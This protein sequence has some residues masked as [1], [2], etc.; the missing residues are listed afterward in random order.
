MLIRSIYVKH[1]LFL[2][3]PRFLEL[4]NLTLPTNLTPTANHTI[5][6][7]KTKSSIFMS[8]FVRIISDLIIELTSKALNSKRKFT[9]LDSILY[10]MKYTSGISK[11]TAQNTVNIM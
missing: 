11:K 8:L 7:N 2:K 5:P 9:Q 6:L 3:R 1:C 4:A 10:Q